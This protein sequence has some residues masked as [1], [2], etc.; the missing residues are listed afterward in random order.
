MSEIGSTPLTKLSV[1]VDDRHEGQ[2][3]LPMP[4]AAMVSRTPSPNTLVMPSSTFVP[5]PPISVAVA[6]NRRR[7][8]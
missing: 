8:M 6:R 1:C 3:A 4:V 5:T 2:V 7:F